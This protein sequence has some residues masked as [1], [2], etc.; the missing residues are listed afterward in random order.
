MKAIQDF[1]DKNHDM[2]LKV[3]GVFFFAFLCIFVPGHNLLQARSHSN[4]QAQILLA[5]DEAYQQLQQELNELKT[6]NQYYKA[7]LGERRFIFNEIQ[8]LAKNIYF[9]AA[10]EPLH[11]KIAVAQVTMNR[12]RSNRY[13]DTVCSVV[14]QR[15]PRGCQFS[16]V[17]EGTKFIRDGEGWKQSL[18]IAEEVLLL[19]RKYSI[20]SAS[21]KYY[22][23]DYVSPRWAEEKTLV[24]KIGRHMFYH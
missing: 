19:K 7:S 1:I 21:A 10:T 6:E 5:K 4:E 22:H 3:G 18:R 13:P 11:G 17:C 16:W 14:Y 15:N 9:E 20:L 12:V 8:C 24:A 2:L 23:A